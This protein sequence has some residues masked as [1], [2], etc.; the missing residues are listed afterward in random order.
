M[1][2]KPRILGIGIATMDIYR[3]QKRMYPGGNEYNVAYNAALQGIDAGFMGIFADDAAGRILEKTLA[4][5]GID[6][7]HSHHEKGSSGY[8]LVD[9]RD[10]DRI[11]LDWNRQGVT[12]L[13]PFTFTEEEIAYI[14]TFDVACI[15]WGARVGADKIRKLSGAG[16]EV[17]YDFYDNFTQEDIENISPYIKYAFFS[18][19][20][21]DEEETR[22][23]LEECVRL[24]ARIAVGTRGGEPAVAYD[25]ARYYSQDI[26]KVTAID[27]MGAGD[28]Y[29]SAFLSNYLSAEADEP[30]SAEDKITISLK[31]AAEF[32]AEVVVKDGSLG[33]GYDVDPENL[34]KIINI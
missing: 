20:H 19:S 16:I 12:D 28:S 22:G 6:T 26:C 24:G 31:K 9:L 18:C 25:G 7:S 2:R 14:K 32:A 29:I 8:A 23:I 3:H 11:F 10:G 27:T 17:C 1:N 13:Y 33:V 5:A 4:D 21:I 30:L 15:S 34:S